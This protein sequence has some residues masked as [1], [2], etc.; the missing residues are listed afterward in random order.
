MKLLLQVLPL[1]TL[2][3]W[4]LNK[5]IVLLDMYQD[6]NTSS[7]QLPIGDLEGRIDKRHHPLLVLRFSQGGHVSQQTVVCRGAREQKKINLYRE[8]AWVVR[9]KS[10]PDNLERK[11]GLTIAAMMKL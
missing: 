5:Q 8:G 3:I 10:D 2:L 11:V 4:C 9:Q 1:Q 6:K 7:T